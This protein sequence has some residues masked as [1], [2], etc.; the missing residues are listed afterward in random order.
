MSQSPFAL[1][2]YYELPDRCAVVNA[3]ARTTRD[4]YA[5][6]TTFVRLDVAERTDERI[7]SVR[8]T[9]PVSDLAS[10]GW[11]VDPE[12]IANGPIQLE[13]TGGAEVDQLL[14]RSAAR[15]RLTA[16]AEERRAR[17]EI[18]ELRAEVAAIRSSHPTVASLELLAIDLARQG[19]QA[20]SEVEYLEE[21][22]DPDLPTPTADSQYARGLGDAFTNAAK[23]IQRQ[24]IAVET[25]GAPPEPRYDDALDPDRTMAHE[26]IWSDRER[27]RE[28]GISNGSTSDFPDPASAGLVVRYSAL[29]Q[30]SSPP[31][32]EIA[33]A[34]ER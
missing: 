3:T 12:A 19:Q 14:A 2:N 24:I 27:R 26:A 7:W 29:D 6:T 20:L 32:G 31:R 23:N 4:G 13:P 15:A 22:T 1:G 5:I 18:M 21:Q 34:F 8:S 28:Y 10:D 9:T 33:P 30:Q 16:S 11:A 17:E 25:T